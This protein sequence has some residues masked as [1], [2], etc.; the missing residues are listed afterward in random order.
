M[1]MMRL[2]EPSDLQNRVGHIAADLYLLH[3]GMGLGTLATI[4]QDMD[5]FGEYSHV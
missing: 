4:I 5:E 1:R 3:G 2:H